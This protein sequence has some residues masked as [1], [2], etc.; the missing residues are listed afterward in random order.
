MQHII[1]LNLLIL[2]CMGKGVVYTTFS[3]HI[4]DKFP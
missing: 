2:F 1:E 3:L 4:S